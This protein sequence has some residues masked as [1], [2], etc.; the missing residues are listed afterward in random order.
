MIFA[1]FLQNKVQGQEF[2]IF[3]SSLLIESQTKLV[4]YLFKQ[5]NFYSKMQGF[6]VLENFY[7][8]EYYLVMES[9]GTYFL[10]LILLC[11]DFQ[12]FYF[13]SIYF[14]LF[15]KLCLNQISFQTFSHFSNDFYLIVNKLFNDYKKAGFRLVLINEVEYLIAYLGF[16]QELKLQFCFFFS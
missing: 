12:M 2:L 1:F 5:I 9:R 6:Q 11:A 4:Y 16:F 8:T 14:Y 15:L 10:N 7:L 13:L 3:I